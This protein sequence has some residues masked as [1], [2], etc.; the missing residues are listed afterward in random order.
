VRLSE[1]TTLEL[2]EGKMIVR[3]IPTLC[4]ACTMQNTPSGFGKD[5]QFHWKIGM[6]RLV[7]SCCT[8]NGVA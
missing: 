4:F 1:H 6:P 8:G 2:T 7:L 3:S 5:F